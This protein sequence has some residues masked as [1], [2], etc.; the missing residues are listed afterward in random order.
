M[1]RFNAIN[2]IHDHNIMEP[3]ARI[4]SSSIVPLSSITPTL[5]FDSPPPSDHLISGVQHDHL[6][7]HTTMA[8]TDS[9]QHQ[10]NHQHVMDIYDHLTPYNCCYDEQFGLVTDWQMHDNHGGGNGAF[11]SPDLW[12]SNALPSFSSTYLKMKDAGPTLAELNI[13]DWDSVDVN[14]LLASA[15]TLA[16]SAGYTTSQQRSSLSNNMK[17]SMAMAH[18]NY[19]RHVREKENI[20]NM[21]DELSGDLIGG[22]MPPAN[23][24]LMIDTKPTLEDIEIAASAYAS[25][26]RD[27]AAACPPPPPPPP[28]PKMCIRHSC[29]SLAPQPPPPLVPIATSAVTSSVQ[30]INKLLTI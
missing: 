25:G 18:D 16:N 10:H 6:S 29:G 21:V 15:A 9:H 23:Q 22:Q 30:V 7:L 17:Q 19:N 12:P 26:C 11:T 4:T 20:H 2:D 3:F 13:V 28:Q 14:E 5:S 1:V 27:R 8:T 24:S